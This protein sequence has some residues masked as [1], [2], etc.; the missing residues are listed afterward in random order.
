M[1]DFSPSEEQEEVRRLAH[2]LSTDLL[3]P[4]ARYVEKLGD[5]PLDVMRKLA[6]TG[7]TMP[8]AEEYGGS[9]SLD[10][11]TYAL[12]AEELGFGDAGLALNVCGSLMGPLCVELGGSVA[13][14]EAYIPPFCDPEQG[15]QK[16]GCLGL[17]E[18]GGGYALAHI[19]TMLSPKG[20]RY[21]LHGT[22]R[23]V[24]HGEVGEPRIILARM[25][26]KG[27]ISGLCAI[28]LP[29]QIDGLTIRSE[30]QKLGLR[31]APS[32]TLHFDQ[33]S[34]PEEALLGRPGDEGLLRAIAFYMFLR[35]GVA[36]GVTR[37]ALEYASAYAEERIAFQRPIVSYQGIAFL[38][39]EMAMKLDAVRLLLWRTAT[40]WD[41]NQGLVLLLKDAE[42]AQ[43]QAVRLAQSATTDAVQ[44]L[45][46]A[47]FMQDHPVEMWMRN[48]AT[49]E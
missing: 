4:Q 10:A 40:R 46:G 8:F 38:L 17:A 37:S 30:R 14:R 20:D 23:D 43:R 24:L 16:R 34:L 12:I 22:K 25:E 15:A 32:A 36:C 42:A 18:P 13:Q 26:G 49:M 47:G 19:Q 44:I 45:G 11:L 29:A 6:Q 28:I 27:D 39:A 3:R 35:A 33:I 41:Q 9:G 2:S 48:A 1:L 31:A 21:I 7:L 5:I